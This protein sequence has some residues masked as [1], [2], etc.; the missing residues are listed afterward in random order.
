VARI[1][2][3]GSALG[4]LGAALLRSAEAEEVRKEKSA[5]L[6]AEL[7]QKRDTAKLQADTQM[8]V[9]REQ[10]EAKRIGLKTKELEQPWGAWGP[11][12]TLAARAGVDGGTANKLVRFY[13]GDTA[14]MSPEEVNQARVLAA[15]ER[16]KAAVSQTLGGDAGYKNWADG[17]EQHAV[18][19][20]IEQL[21]KHNAP[22]EA[23]S[24][25]VA[26]RDKGGLT[27]SNG[28]VNKATGRM[29]PAGREMLASRER[30]ARL[31]A[32]GSGN[33]DALLRAVI[34]E[35]MRSDGRKDLEQ[36][37]RDDAAA[38]AKA[39]NPFTKAFDMNTYRAE[40]QARGYDERASAGSSAPLGGGL[41]RRNG[42]SSVDM[43]DLF[44]TQ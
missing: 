12:A 44:G 21:Q 43:Y 37:K 10:A 35:G 38:R 26:M 34:V 15:S 7:E 14:G 28:M 20:G 8:A 39:T 36:Y 27:T 1:T 9:A 22:P 31:S 13:K 2:G 18:T 40:M 3:L 19:V 17:N 16:I 42:P 24:Q 23:V 32:S 5:K 29:T 6:Q 11:E 30:E 4:E 25:F 41:L 33:T